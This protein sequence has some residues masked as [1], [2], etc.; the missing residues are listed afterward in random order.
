[1]IP[2]CETYDSELAKVIIDSALPT[3][4][5]LKRCAINSCGLADSVPAI[6][7]APDGARLVVDTKF[8]RIWIDDIEIVGLQPDSHPFRFIEIMARSSVRVSSEEMSTKLSPGRQDGNTSAR[9]AKNQVKKTITA[10]MAA[11][12]RSFDEDPFPSAGSGHYRCAFPSHV[13]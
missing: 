13:R 8:S 12:G 4:R 3:E 10:A 5:E 11:A 2:A 7:A 6:H 1:L 9:Q